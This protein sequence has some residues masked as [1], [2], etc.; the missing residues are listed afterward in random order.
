[1][2]PKGK[3]ARH[4]QRKKAQAKN[5]LFNQN[6]SSMDNTDNSPII[7]QREEKQEI[8]PSITQGDEIWNDSTG[9]AIVDSAEAGS[10]PSYKKFKASDSPLPEE[11]VSNE[12]FGSQPVSSISVHLACHAYRSSRVNW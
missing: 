3:Q 5:N 1:M 2:S 10:E 4:S 7:P 9:V 11:L 8:R 12:G 6:S